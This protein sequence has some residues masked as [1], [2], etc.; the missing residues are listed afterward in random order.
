VW[1]RYADWTLARGNCSTRGDYRL[2][3]GNIH[4][5]GKLDALDGNDRNR[6]ILCIANTRERG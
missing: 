6:R 2:T 3:L 4:G 1:K 5:A